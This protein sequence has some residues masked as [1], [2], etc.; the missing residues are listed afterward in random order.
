VRRKPWG[1]S[2]KATTTKGR[3]ALSNRVG[4]FEAWGREVTD[5][6]WGPPEGDGGSPQTVLIRDTSRSIINYNQSPD[7]PFDRSI[8]P[9][10]GCEH[11]CV[12]CYARPSH[13]YLGH[14]PGLDFETHIHY[15]PDAAGLL[16]Q[17]LARPAYRCATIALGANT[18][19]YQP[20]ERRL[21]ITRQVL[22]TLYE[23]RHPVGIITKAAL[24]ERDLDLLAAM[25]RE[26]LVQVSVSV[27]TLDG[28]L[29]RRMEPRAASPRRR[30]ATVARLRE[31]G[32]PVGL[33][34]APVIPALNDTEMEAVMEQAYA[35]GCRAA[36]YVLLRLPLEIKDLFQEWLTTHYPL[37]SE[38]IMNRIRDTRDGRLYDPAFGARMRGTGEY[39]RLIRQRFELACRRIGYGPLPPL[40]TGHFMPP[41][42]NPDQLS[43]F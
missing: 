28:E 17:A 24:I 36:D 23:C 16:R 41:S 9:Y 27:T 1:E 30:L 18:D 31:A 26:Q 37:K 19:P 34:F 21:G 4:R 22:E 38:R 15:K 5:D 20:V 40:D 11:G 35:A 42:A 12:Y 39:A 32:V 6:G 29:A 8:N 10:R 43:L 25:A 3:G 14:S 13:A 7:V 33:L 2:M